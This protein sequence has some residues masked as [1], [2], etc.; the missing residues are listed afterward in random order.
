LCVRSK[1]MKTSGV[2]SRGRYAPTPQ[3]IPFLRIYGG[4]GRDKRGRGGSK[5]MI[6][7]RAGSKIVRAGSKIKPV[8]CARVG[9]EWP[10]ILEKM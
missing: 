2:V 3:K 1:S 7:V 8:G 9:L 10:A 4:P 5:M 6:G